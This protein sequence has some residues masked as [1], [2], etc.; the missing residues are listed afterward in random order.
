MFK[1]VSKLIFLLVLL[2]SRPLY[3]QNET[4]T[5]FDK[6]L[7]VSEKD[8]LHYRL[9]RPEN[10]G[11]KDAFP[12]V[13][14][15][16]G[17]GERGNDNEVQVKHITGLF[18]DPG[19]RIQY[20]SYVLAPQCPQGTTWAARDREAPRVLMRDEPTRPMAMLIE[21]I[22]KIENEFPI[23]RT[24]IYVT[25]LSMGGYGTWDLI[26]RFPDRFAA[27]VPICGGGDTRTAI[28]IRHVPIW[29]FHGAL[30]KVVIPEHSRLMIKALQDAGGNPGYTE[31]PGV[32]H[33]SWVNAYNDPQLLPWMFGQQLEKDAKA[34]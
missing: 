19:N 21:L 11:T 14:F 7:Y 24:R 25:G 8:T 34:K 2:Y 5:G 6:L 12:L 13:I 30:D 9:L 17:A 28:A 29:A 15:L 22:T 27:A 31:Y 1:S 23:D 3:A 32:G 26:A 10:P 18:L 33:D 4:A 20:P 16:H